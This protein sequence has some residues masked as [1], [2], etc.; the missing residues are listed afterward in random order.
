MRYSHCSFHHRSFQRTQ[1]ELEPTSLR[2][3][4]AERLASSKP[5]VRPN[6]LFPSLHIIVFP[7]LSSRSNSEYAPPKSPINMQ[8]RFQPDFRGSEELAKVAPLLMVVICI[9]HASGI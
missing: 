4:L 2:G 7:R 6:V 1:R 3:N 5:L 8:H 9:T